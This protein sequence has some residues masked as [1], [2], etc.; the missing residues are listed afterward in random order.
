MAVN[1]FVSHKNSPKPPVARP[2]VV[3]YRILYVNVRSRGVA[4]PAAR[5]T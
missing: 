5:L 1:K 3:N 2:N 4:P